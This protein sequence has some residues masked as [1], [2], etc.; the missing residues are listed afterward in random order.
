MLQIDIEN[1]KRTHTVTK[2]NVVSREGCRF[3]EM[4]QPCKLHLRRASICLLPI[5]PK[6]RIKMSCPRDRVGA[7]QE[8]FPGFAFFRVGVGP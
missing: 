5:S 1:N 4:I 6:K 7:K 8:S 2:T 3:V